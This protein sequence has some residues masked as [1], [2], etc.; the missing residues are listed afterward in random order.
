MHGMN[1]S[2][3]ISCETSNRFL[4][5]SIENMVINRK[6]MQIGPLSIL[7]V[8]YFKN[9][10]TYFIHPLIVMIFMS[11]DINIISLFS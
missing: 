4:Q 10:S 5:P 1:P 6:A 7:I 8:K 9:R 2:I 3:H 11:I